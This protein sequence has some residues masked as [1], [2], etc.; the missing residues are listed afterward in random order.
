VTTPQQ[1]PPSA[2]DEREDTAAEAGIAAAAVMA[3]AEVTILVAMAAAITS[4]VAGSLGVQMAKRKVM[5]AVAAALGAASAKIRQVHATAAQDATAAG[6]RAAASGGPGEAGGEAGGQPAG[7]RA[8]QEQAAAA[9]QPGAGPG[10][11]EAPKRVTQ[12]KGHGAAPPL[13]GAPGQ[14]DKAVLNAQRDAGQA[15]DAA[16]FAAL[17]GKGSP[18]PP[19]NPY[20]DAVDKA[21]RR[22][23]GIGADVKDLTGA[24]RAAQSLSRLKASQVVLDDLASQGLTGFTDSRGRRW[25]LDAYAEMA[26]RTAASRLHLSTQLGMMAEA[27]NDLVIVDNPSKAAPCPLCRPYEGKVLSLSGK[28]TGASTITDASGVERTEQVMTSLA[29][30]VAHG[31]LHPNCRHSLIPWT[32]GA[33]AVATAGGKERGYVEH[34]QPIS[35]PLPIGTPGQYEDEQK[36]RGHERNV[37][38]ASMR[39]AAAVT[40]QAKVQ[41]RARL[42]HARAGLEAHVKATGALRQPRREKAG[43][44]R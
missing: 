20:R 43:V 42:T 3:A 40:P 13:P 8:A 19:S 31:L 14:I 38:A 18:L 12:H 10:R 37:R 6:A 21:M 5:R 1:P 34:N 7:S 9:T 4:V 28:T 16:M 11:A 24:E 23:T 26:T 22:L 32:E 25:S 27:G 39:L 36:L 29:D 15:F 17:G 33:G 41:A 44:A 2:G 30:A 35:E